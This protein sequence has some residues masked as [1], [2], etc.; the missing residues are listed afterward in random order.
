MVH[1]HLLI[2]GNAN[3]VVHRHQKLSIKAGQTNDGSGQREDFCENE[4]HARTVFDEEK[5]E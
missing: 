2:A 4:N 3:A 5:S 1:R